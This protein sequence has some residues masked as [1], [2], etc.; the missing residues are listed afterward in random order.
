MSGQGFSPTPCSTC[1][2]GLSVIYGTKRK[3][4]I[5]VPDIRD[6]DE[7]LEGVLLIGFADT[8]LDFPL[9]FSL[10]LFAMSVDH[11]VRC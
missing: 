5:R 9:D 3:R 7:D 11:L 4:Y 2:Y 6:S 10:A 8:S 1:E